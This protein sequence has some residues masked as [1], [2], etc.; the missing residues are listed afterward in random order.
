[1]A[2]LKEKIDAARTGQLSQEGAEKLKQMILSGRLDAMAQQEGID[3]EPFK[4][5]HGK[6]TV[7]TPDFLKRAG[8]SIEAQTTDAA[9]KEKAQNVQVGMTTDV[10]PPTTSTDPFNPFPVE[11]AKTDLLDAVAKYGGPAGQVSSDLA[12]TTLGHAEEGLQTVKQGV[13]EMGQAFKEPDVSSGTTKF[14]EG[15]ADVIGGG[16]ST[17]FSPLSTVI[18]KTPVVNTL[19]EKIGEGQDA[20]STFLADK[21]GTTEEEKTALKKSFNNLMNLGVIKYGPKAIETVKSTVSP[22]L[23]TAGEKLSSAAEN[24]PKIKMGEPTPEVTSIAS[25]QGIEL[26][27]SAQ[28]GSEFIKSLE[29]LQKNGIFSGKLLAK[30]EAATAKIADLTTKATER[31]NA[32]DLSKF[33]V[34]NITKKGF[35]KVKDTF[36][37]TKGHLY[38]A[39]DAA[40]SESKVKGKFIAAP[41][42]TIAALDE[43]IGSSKKS[44]APTAASQFWQDLKTGFTS[45]KITVDTLR[46]TLKDIGKKMGDSNDP[47]VTGDRAGF[48]KVYGAL[49]R[50]LDAFYMEK[51]PQFKDAITKANDY[52]KQNIELLNG[53]FGSMLE[54]ATPE[55]IYNKFVKPNNPTALG[56]L[57]QLIGGKSFAKISGVFTKD[58]LEKSVKND[59]FSIDAF[60]KEIGKWDAK[61]LKSILDKKQLTRLEEVKTQLGS[62][63]TL[64]DA[65]KSGEAKFKG[66]QTGFLNAANKLKNIFAGG[67]TVTAGLLGGV[68]GVIATALLYV[69]GDLATSKFLLSDFAKRLVTTGVNIPGVGLAKSFGDFIAQ[70][71][72]AVSQIMAATPV[73]SSLQSTVS[74]KEAQQQ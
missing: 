70:N 67:G 15:T 49:A 30:S 18:E 61:T 5:Q 45:G 37:R 43:L 29:A 62:L 21:I 47:I 41:S 48:S 3:L 27:L 2:T 31:L 58:L 64:Q 68:P 24:I 36:Q 23:T 71:A 55:Q 26:P 56:E 57:K 39:A 7:E 11:G 59:Q 52:Y 40:L 65:I 1:M 42:E 63:K 22:Y 20:V 17:A 4:N 32:S 33:D 46:Q 19:F 38:D 6:K 28:T 72:D 66:S 16:L 44:L 13:G 54:N 53:K 69:L 14:V 73:I 74:D 12:K 50:D 34:G 10:N 9:T 51:A 60:N 25:T 35:D 8:A